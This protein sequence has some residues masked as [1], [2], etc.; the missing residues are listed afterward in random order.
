MKVPLTLRELEVL[1]YLKKFKKGSIMPTRQDLA[2]HFGIKRST[3]EFFLSKLKK[4][5]Y[6]KTS[7]MWRS[8]KVINS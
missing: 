7:R 6:V 4:K 1:T 8:I 2:D 5:G 3:A